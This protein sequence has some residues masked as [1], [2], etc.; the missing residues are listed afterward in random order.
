MG[1][2]VGGAFFKVF[3]GHYK[4]ELIFGFKLRK[5]KNT[6]VPHNYSLNIVKQNIY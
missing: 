1:K 6:K 2:K 5:Q 4:L 3:V